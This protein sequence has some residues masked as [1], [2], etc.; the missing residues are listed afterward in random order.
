MKVIETIERLRNYVKKM[1]DINLRKNVVFKKNQKE[2]C[3][4]KIILL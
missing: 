2:W 4:V 3:C 1:F